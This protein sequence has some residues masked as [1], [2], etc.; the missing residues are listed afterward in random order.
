MDFFWPSGR[1]WIYWVVVVEPAYCNN[2][3]YDC[4]RRSFMVQTFSWPTCGSLSSLGCPLYRIDMPYLKT[5]FIILGLR[6]NWSLLICFL[7]NRS[8]FCGYTWEISSSIF[9]LTIFTSFCCLSNFTIMWCIHIFYLLYRIWPFLL[10]Q[11]RKGC[12]AL[13]LLKTLQEWF[14]LIDKWIDQRLP[15]AVLR[16][17]CI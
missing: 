11:Q 2:A 16:H 10:L 17:P 12:L 6:S 9:R 14:L 8:C 15:L 3:G 4:R 5:S 13:S 7:F 1:P